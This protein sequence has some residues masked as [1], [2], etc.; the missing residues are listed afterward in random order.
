MWLMWFF[1]Y[2]QITWCWFHD[3]MKH[4]SFSHSDLFQRIFRNVS[5]WPV[6]WSYSTSVA[7]LECSVVFLLQQTELLKHRVHAC[8]RCL[9]FP[10][11]LSWGEW[12]CQGVAAEFQHPRAKIILLWSLRTCWSFCWWDCQMESRQKGLGLW[13]C[14][15]C[16][17]H[18]EIRGGKRECRSK[19]AA[20]NGLRNRKCWGKV[21][22]VWRTKKKMMCTGM[23]HDSRKTPDPPWEMSNPSGTRSSPFIVRSGWVLK[24]ESAGACC[25][26]SLP[27]SEPLFLLVRLEELICFKRGKI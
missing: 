18:R 6:E 1:S 19:Q 13:R 27:K 26:L 21:L 23:P 2:L 7:C 8:V 3:I 9:L 14:M 10:H 17:K 4:L 15:K 25:L 11:P 20:T 24:S 5:L 12:N 16:G 22:D